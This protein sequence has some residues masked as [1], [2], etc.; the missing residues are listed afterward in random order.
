MSEKKTNTAKQEQAPQDVENIREI[1]FGS[2]MRDYETQFKNF[3]S[4]IKRLQQEIDQLNEKLQALQRTTRKADNDLRDEL[5][6]TAQQLTEDKVDRI[7]LSDLLVE[8]G[9]YLK[10]GGSLANTLKEKLEKKE[11]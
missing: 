5:R 6:Q 10:T 2:Q 7:L 9:G 11:E 3:Q 8:L 1:L 4:D